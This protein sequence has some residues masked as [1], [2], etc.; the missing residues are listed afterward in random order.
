MSPQLQ[1]ELHTTVVLV[2]GSQ[3]E[4]SVAVLVLSIHI[5]PCIKGGESM[6]IG[7]HR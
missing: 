6:R 5:R 1:Q 7:N 4:G 3:V 2:E